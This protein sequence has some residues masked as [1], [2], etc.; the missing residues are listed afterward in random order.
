MEGHKPGMGRNSAL[1]RIG[2]QLQVLKRGTN[3]HALWDSGLIR[4][5]GEDGPA[6]TKRLLPKSMSLGP[7]CAGSAR[8][9]EESCKIVGMPGYYPKRKVTGDYFE[10]FTPIMEARLAL[11]GARLAELLNKVLVP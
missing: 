11:A 7:M 10:K 6:M 3:L 4:Q 8:A 9:A 2:Y 1:G 5:L